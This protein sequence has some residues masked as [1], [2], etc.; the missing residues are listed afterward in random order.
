M[1]MNGARRPPWPRGR[2]RS[3][4]AR[5]TNA[6]VSGACS[7]LA[8]ADTAATHGPRRRTPS[9]RR[10]ACASCAVAPA[11]GRLDAV[12]DALSAKARLIVPVGAMDSRWCCGCRAAGSARGGA[13]QTRGEGALATG[14]DRHRM[15]GTLPA[16]GPVRP[17]PRKP[18]RASLGDAPG[19]GARFGRAVGE[20]QHHEG[21]PR[22][23]K[24]RPTR[25]LSVACRCCSRQRPAPSCRARCP[26]C[27]PR[28][29]PLA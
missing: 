23:V 6:D 5:C 2:S 9:C 21:S 1:S 14:R 22:P 12:A 8:D 17:T 10:P 7:P 19:L 29:G 24:P 27:A 18:R 20:T 26:A 3:G 16:R 28:R 4:P 11:E 13:R 25:R 15:P